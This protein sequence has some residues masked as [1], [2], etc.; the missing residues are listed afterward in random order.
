MLHPIFEKILAPFTQ[1]LPMKHIVSL[2]LELNNRKVKLIEGSE[3]NVDVKKRKLIGLENPTHY[4]CS[5]MGNRN[6][7]KFE[8]CC[9]EFK[10][11]ELICILL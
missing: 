3:V 9:I 11:K 4:V 8:I 7:S 1:P 10:T 5:L 6:E 2:T